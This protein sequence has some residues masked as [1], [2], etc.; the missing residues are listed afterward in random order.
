MINPAMPR[1]AIEPTL[2]E[3]A[4]VVAVDLSSDTIGTVDAVGERDE[5]A[6]VGDLVEGAFVGDL[7]VQIVGELVGVEVTKTLRSS[8][9]RSNLE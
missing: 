7:V 9:P 3:I 8:D 1:M 6:L 5:G 2:A 4:V